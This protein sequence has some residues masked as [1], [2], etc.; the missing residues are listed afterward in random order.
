MFRLFS[1]LSGKKA[2]CRPVKAHANS[3]QEGLHQHTLKTLGSGDLSSAVALPLGEDLN[4]WFASNTVDF[5]N[6]VSLIWGIIC[7]T[8]LPN[9]RAGEGFPPGFEYLWADGVT[10]KTPLVCS[11]SEYVEYVMAWVEGQVNNEAVF[12]SS[13]SSAFPKNY[14]AVVKQIFT[15]MFRLYAIVYSQHFSRLEEMG[16]AA[17]LNT[18]FKHFLFFIWEF[19]LVDPRELGALSRI[20]GELRAVYDEQKAGRSSQAH[21]K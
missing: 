10:V 5:F 9:Y 4:E 16:A 14:L 6:E 17:H 11:S 2:T 20:V 21:R 18:S 13:A 1:G 19:E 12:P 3:K 8:G 15:R 7:D